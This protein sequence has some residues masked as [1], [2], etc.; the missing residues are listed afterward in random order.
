ML[1]ESA[2][3]AAPITTLPL[4]S[5]GFTLD[6]GHV[7]V[8]KDSTEIAYSGE[9]LRE[10]MAQDGY[11][12]LPGWLD[13]QEVLDARAGIT[14]KLAAE[15]L[16]N[17]D[18]PHEDGVIKPGGHGYF[19]PEWA[20]KNPP[21][22]KMLYSGRMMEFYT[23]FLNGP[24]LHYDFTWLRT[25]APGLGTGSH[26]D[27]VYMGRGTP[28]LY[29]SWTPLGDVSYELGGLMI[30]ENSHHNQRLRDTYGKGD[31]DAYCTNKTGRA[32]KDGWHAKN[33]GGLSKNPNQIRKSLGGRW[34]VSEYKAG[35]LLLFSMFTVH[36]SLDNHSKDRYRLST[37]SRYQLANEAVDERWVGE[38]PVG[39]S[40]AGK[41]GKIC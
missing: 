40:Q 26:C 16:L 18:Y 39:H 23:R 12:Y 33:G 3:V 30:L 15:G 25:V 35:D 41:R 4:K 19:K 20:M 17:P 1:V 29:T 28:N 32:G 36:A 37:D 14:S 24:V 13:R 10:R 6:P 31:V 7:G 21:V 34:L 22:E 38:N 8:L 2:P 9:A 5:C 27:I 11:L